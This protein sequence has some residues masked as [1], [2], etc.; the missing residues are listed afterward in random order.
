MAPPHG[1]RVLASTLRP[2]TSPAEATLRGEGSP[3]GA[4][5]RKSA[6]PD[7]V[8]APAVVATAA[9]G[10]AFAAGK[11]GQVKGCDDDDKGG[12][13]CV[14][15][16][17]AETAEPT[18]TRPRVAKASISSA[19]DFDPSDAATGPG[20]AGLLEKKREPPSPPMRMP[21]AN[22]FGTEPEGYSLVHAA[23]R[24]RRDASAAA[25]AADAADAEAEAE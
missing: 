17:S 18:L 22:P 12:H 19:S 11:D 8:F 21:K 1:L 24:A 14:P 4:R 15:K 2:L 7:D 13:A 6:R 20:P 16:P 23:K 9:A 10:G 25:A 3:S 5:K